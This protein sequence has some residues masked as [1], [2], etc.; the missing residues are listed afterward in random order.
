MVDKD[1]KILDQKKHPHSD[2]KGTV[3]PPKENKH[4]R[5]RPL[6]DYNLNDDD[7]DYLDE[8]DTYR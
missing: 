1:E 5:R 4:W 2:K 6:Q 8:E 3:K 7:Y